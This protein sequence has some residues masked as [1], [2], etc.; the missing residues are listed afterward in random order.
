MKKLKKQLCFTLF[1]AMLAVSLL[2]AGCSNGDD[3]G[4]SGDVTYT[5]TVKDALGNACGSGIVVKLMQNGEQKAMLTCDENGVASK[6]L[7]KGDYTVELAFTGD[8]SG[9]YYE[10]AAVLT[11]ENNSTE[12]ILS[13]KTANSTELFDPDGEEVK[14]YTITDGCTFVEL[15]AEKRNY[16]IYTPVSAGNYRFSVA[17]GS[18][19]AIGC[20]GT[21]HFV[22]KTSLYETKDNAF[23]VSVNAG[24]IGADAS[25]G[26]TSVFVIGIDAKG[27][28]SCIICIDRIGDP[29]K[30]IDD[31]PWT[32]YEK[33]VELKQYTLPE[34]AQIK[35]F[36]LTAETDEYKLVLNGNDGFYHLGSEDGAIVLVRLAQD[37]DYIACYKTMLDSTTISKY[38]FDE[39][40]KYIKKESYSQCLLDYIECVDEKNGVYPLTEDLKYIIQQHGGYSDWWNPDSISYLF[41]DKNGYNLPEINNEIAWLLMC[42]YAE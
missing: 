22:Q 13:K 9:F 25:A 24:M 32:I 12:I 28:S 16:F 6:A 21:P 26:G 23:E 4:S 5:V 42:C 34:G 20:Y 31:E 19:A 37:C 8:E 40:G 29:I 17:N 7:P 36:D 18:D 41:Q 38:F 33:T 15:E 14:A 27:N 3:A 35:E 10:K 30:T 1:I 11:A 39:D 2:L